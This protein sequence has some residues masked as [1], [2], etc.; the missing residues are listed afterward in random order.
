MTDLPSVI[1][2][3]QNL[4]DV[5][6]PPP[7]PVGQYPAEIVSVTPTTSQKSGKLYAKTVFRIRPE[8]Y[9]P[10]FS[11]DNAP[12]GKTLTYNLIS[13]E[14]RNNKQA[15]NSLKRFYEALKLPLN[16]TSINTADWVGKEALITVEHTQ[17]LKG[18]GLREE[19]TRISSL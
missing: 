5:Q 14:L 17:S 11:I 16:T 12:S 15:L 4:E 10:D 19:I 6:A 1:D 18:D 2:L 3:G 8:N 13:L 9:P 7:L